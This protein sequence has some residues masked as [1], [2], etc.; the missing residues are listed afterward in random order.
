M[1]VGVDDAFVILE[2][3]QSSKVPLQQLVKRVSSAVG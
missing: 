2:S 1:G 3:V